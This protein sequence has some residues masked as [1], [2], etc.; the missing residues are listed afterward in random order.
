MKQERL[1]VIGNGMVGQK[2]L[3]HLVADGLHHR[4]QVTV[5]CAEPRPA[6]DRVHLSEFFTGRSS[7]DL[8]LVPERFF[9]RH[10]LELRLSEGAD[11]IDLQNKTIRTAKGATLDYDKL[12]LATGSYPFVPPVPGRGRPSCLVYRT[13][14]DLEAIMASGRDAEVGAVIGGGLLGLEAAKALRDIG[15]QTHVVEFA[16]RLMAVQVDDG[17]GALLRRKIEQ[18]GVFVHTGMNTTEIIDGEFYRHR[19]NFADGGHLEADLVVFSAGIRPQDTLARDAGLAVGERGGIVIDNHCRTSDPDVY[20]IGECALWG[21][22]IYGLVAPG[23]EMARAAVSHL[24]HR[25]DET[26]AVPFTGADMSTKLKL[27]GVDVASL[28]DAHASTPG[29]CCYRYED[30][31]KQI[32]KKLVV[33]ED[34]RRLLGGVLVG[35]AREYNT[36]LQLMLNDMA[37]PETPEQL[38]LPA[39]QGA[40][41]ALDV[42]RL[43]DSATLCQCQN[44]TKGALCQAIAEGHCDLAAIKQCTGAATGCG[45]CEPM[46]R[47]LLDTFGVEA[48]ALAEVGT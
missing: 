9:E 19:L 14:E 10:G 24:R 21:G 44:V 22:R 13:I 8:S 5:L 41:P 31:R 26:L 11:S 33:S 48:D 3:D 28:G 4:Y 34:G 36:L 7:E 38:I 29:A 2:Y 40:A 45:G 46:V 23:Y 17:G 27:M 35:D 1:V 15:L 25:R 12:V 18:L 20:A 6:Y 39:A 43:P 42:T 47:S 30:E 37:L 16:P 32:Y